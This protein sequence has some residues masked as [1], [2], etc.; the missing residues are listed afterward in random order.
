MPRR[1]L[2]QQE[3]QDWA[4]FSRSIRRLGEPAL[5]ADPEPPAPTPR[6]ASARA[7]PPPPAPARPPVQVGEQPG[8]LDSASWHRFRTGKLGPARTLDLH[9]RTAQ[10]AF[11]AVESFLLSA[12]AEG[13]RCVEII[14]GRGSGKSGG[15]LKRELPVWLN[16][17]T[18]R[19]LILAASYPH[20]ANPGAVR[21]LLRRVR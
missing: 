14:T 3:R 1:V 12:Q 4:A 20:P 15:I 10:L 18:L 9:G 21:V 8:G 16:G 19:P 17:P 11:N 2:S 7:V 5:L 6:E 13:L